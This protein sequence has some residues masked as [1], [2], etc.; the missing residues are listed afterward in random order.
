MKTPAN[1]GF[2]TPE[3]AEHCT[4]SKRDTRARCFKFHSRVE[5]RS[6]RQPHKL[7]VV[8]SNPTPATR[9]TTRGAN[10]DVSTGSSHESRTRL[11]DAR[12][13]LPHRRSAAA[14]VGGCG[15]RTQVRPQHEGP[16][17]QANPGRGV[18]RPGAAV[19]NQ[20]P[21]SMLQRSCGAGGQPAGG[22]LS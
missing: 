7:D 2:F 5:Q 21:P 12:P 17:G 15:L 10:R 20:S 11:R 4:P 13:C 8:G 6:A 1:V 3:I 19:I 9:C 14:F 22:V 18:P 16:Q